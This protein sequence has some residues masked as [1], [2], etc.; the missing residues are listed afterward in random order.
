MSRIFMQNE[1]GASAV[2]YGLLVALIAIII[3][4]AVAFLGD[5]LFSVFTDSGTAIGGTDAPTNG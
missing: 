4:A 1:E 5:S 3:I 2:E